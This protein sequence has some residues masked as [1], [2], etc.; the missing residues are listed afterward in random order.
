MFFK[1]MQDTTEIQ[2]KANME[3]KVQ[4][5]SIEENINQIK[6]DI[7]LDQLKQTA[8]EISNIAATLD[9]R[10]AYLNDLSSKLD[11]LDIKV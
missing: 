7:G 11:D 10:N 6:A 2:Q 9:T 1:F 5:K 3:N 8:K 4:L